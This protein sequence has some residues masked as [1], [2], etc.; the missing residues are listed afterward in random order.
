MMYHNHENQQKQRE[1]VE[2]WVAHGCNLLA[3]RETAK[4]SGGIVMIESGPTEHQSRLYFAFVN[5][6][7]L[8]KVTP[9]ER[10]GRLGR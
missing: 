9:I 7:R 8:S 1:I 5:Y 6:A 3:R 10:C 2:K 4:I